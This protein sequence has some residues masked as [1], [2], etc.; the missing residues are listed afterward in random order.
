MKFRTKTV[1]VGLCA[2]LLLG[3]TTP[4]WA[5]PGDAASVPAGGTLTQAAPETGYT[6]YDQAATYPAA[7]ADIV[8]G[9]DAFLPAAS[10]AVTPTA[11][12]TYGQAFPLQSGSSASFA[13]TVPQDARYTL[14]LT[15]EPGDKNASE[16]DFALRI[17]GAYP[18]ADCA[19]LTMNAV[20]VDDGGIRALSNGDE[21]A[22]AQKH[23]E[24]FVTRAVTDKS[25]V[26]L[27]AYEFALAA[28]GHTI[29]LRALDKAF[30]VAQV[31]LGAPERPADYAAVSAN[32]AN[33]PRYD[34]DPIVIEAETAA[35]KNDSALG[36]RSDTSSASV[37]PHS[38][39]R[40]LVNY[41]GGNW[42]QP[43]QEIVWS[44]EVP[45]T[46]LY[47][48]GFS[49]KQNAVIDGEVYR[50][51]RIDGK[52]P[53]A[54]ASEIAFPYGTKW[55][56]RSFADGEGSDYLFYLEQGKHTLSLSVTLADVAQVFERLNG[57]V[58]TLGD[59]YLDMVMITGESPDPNRDYELHK[60]IPNLR[61]TLTENRDLLRQLAAD[62]KGGLRVNGELYG[63]L[64]NMARVL[65][66]ML[67]NMFDAHL[68]VQNY[69]SVY[70]TLSAWL[71]DIKSMSLN[72]DEILLTA[73]DRKPQTGIASW[74]AGVAYTLKRFLYS[75]QG[76]YNTVISDD[77]EQPAVK[78]WVNWGRD[79]VKVLNTLIQDSFTP[80]HGIG[81]QVQQVNATLV[82]G[83]LSGNP[84][85]LYLQMARTEPVNLALRGV[86]TDLSQFPDFEQ[87]L[88]NFQPG[89]EL[90]YRYH[91]GCYALPDTQQF[92]VMFY[93]K[94][95][96]NE[97]GIAV[98]KTW[99][100]FLTATG[101][102]QRNNMNTYLPYTKIAAATTV[103]TG[104]GGL[105]IFPTMLLQT[106][107]SVYNKEQ[108][109]TLLTEP[110]SVQAF[111]M[112]TDFYTRYKLDP[113]ANFYQK[114]RIG[115]IPLGIALYT[116]YLTFLVSAPEIDGKWEMAPLPG[117]R[118]DDGSINNV[119]S[120][121]GTGCGIMRA[122]KHK[123]EA[124]EFLKWWVSADTQYRYSAETEAILGVSGRIATSNIEAL[125]RL[126]WEGNALDVIQT[127][128]KNV[129]EIAEVPGSYYV[130]RSID[131]AFWA[132][133]NEES[134]P[135]EAIAEWALVADQEIERKIAEYAGRVYE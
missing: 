132:A 9:K 17:D 135:K 82:Q 93:R 77:A 107:G 125:S 8:L 76:D 16:Y 63:A 122:S 104:A 88:G 32:Y 22:P 50:W 86:L 35:Y 90:P 134:T 70:Q 72:L 13:V 66:R 112:W 74:G 68:Y 26:A 60:Q 24:G 83:L 21:V 84:P 41:V 78:L 28:G 40:S 56:Y 109:A 99:S 127:Q 128:W 71:Y 53:F 75:F 25:G 101:V 102:L 87:T 15:F 95:I 14:S 98:P 108:N 54:E 97:L 124:W 61:E 79:Q 115:V 51:L 36:G 117:F 38:W 81:V 3:G 42:G 44:F 130:S 129:Q 123:Q 33:L 58:G 92:Y 1:C 121:S 4:A 43:N 106:G 111:E 30:S 89:A 55:V 37:T 103:N 94:D 52:T 39:N 91:G 5:A 100:E 116:Q 133:R 10:S 57:I 45:T 12:G 110:H 114:F 119:C 27:G 64:N 62:I 59:T 65:D 73:P 120:G 49:Y 19:E 6:A 2:L 18:F 31:V 113:D 118:N 69:Y 105:S 85:D 46:G 131:Q 67:E 29:T 34:G 23:K 7:T 48:L 126:S 80:D 96:L 20:W 47:R 11:D